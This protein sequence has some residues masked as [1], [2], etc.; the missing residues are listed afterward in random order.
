MISIGINLYSPKQSYKYIIDLAEEF[1]INHIRFSL[2]IPNTSSDLEGFRKHYEENKTNLLELFKYA[3][4]KH[5]QL[6]QDCN[7]IPICFMTRED[8]KEFIR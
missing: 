2:T 1:G 8:L 7:S 6:Y 5:I 3:A 4:H